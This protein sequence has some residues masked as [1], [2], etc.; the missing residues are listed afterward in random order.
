MKINRPV[1][2][3]VVLLGLVLRIYNLPSRELWYDEAFSAKMVSNSFVDV[4]N[5][6]KLDVHPPLYYLLLKGWT[7]VFGSSEVSLRFPSVIFGVLL[8]PLIYKLIM[9]INS[10]RRKAL[11]ASLFVAINPFLVAHSNDARSY[12]MLCFLTVLTF[13]FVLKA[14][15]EKKYLGVSILLPLLFLT[16]YVAVFGIAVFVVMFVNSKK[17][18]IYLLPVLIIVSLYIP[19]MLGSANSTGL[20]WIPKFTLHRVPETI[21]TFFFVATSSTDI[22]LPAPTNPTPIRGELLYVVLIIALM[23]LVSISKPTKEETLL[24]IAGILPIVLVA[25][26]DTY[27]GKQLFVERYLIGYGT[28]FLVYI[29]TSIPKPILIVYVIVAVYLIIWVKPEPYVFKN[30]AQYADG[31]DRQV[32]IMDANQYIPISYY[33]KKVKLQEGDWASWVIIRDTDIYDKTKTDQAIYLL[34]L[35]QIKDWDYSDRLDNYFFYDS[36]MNR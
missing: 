21:H 4:L 31:L 11:L 17:A 5:L 27:F 7:T 1:L 35:G 12:S 30:I 26:T 3:I 2:L 8:I 32:V 22:N 10:D 29:A 24:L 19:I 28:L 25:M 15:K 23:I 6:S 34:N 33:S 14:V 36:Q 20:D 16:H 9:Y 18:L 13:L